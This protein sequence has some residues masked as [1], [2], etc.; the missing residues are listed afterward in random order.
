MYVT[1]LELQ[2]AICKEHVLGWEI[3]DFSRGF[4]VWSCKVIVSI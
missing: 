2:M 1:G 3:I 4:Q